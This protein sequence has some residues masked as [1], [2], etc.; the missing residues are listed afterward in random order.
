MAHRDLAARLT[1]AEA[2]HDQAL[3]RL[4]AARRAFQTERRRVQLIKAHLEA[5]PGHVFTPDPDLSDEWASFPSCRLC[6]L[7]I[8]AIATREPCPGDQHTCMAEVD[9]GATGTAFQRYGRDSW[10]CGQ[11]GKFLRGYRVWVCAAGHRTD[12]RH[13]GECLRQCVCRFLVLPSPIRRR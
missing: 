2:R 6:S 5:G 4:V 3:T 13:W 1:A 10:L 9:Q 11:P 8:G 12:R 7:S